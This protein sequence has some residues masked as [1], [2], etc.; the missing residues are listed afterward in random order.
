MT[1]PHRATPE[2]WENMTAFENDSFDV[3]YGSCILELRD[4]IEALEAA[5]ASVQ[6]AVK[7]SLTAPAWSLVERVANAVS[8]GVVDGDYTQV[9]R[10]A[11]REVAAWI[12]LE[13]NGRSVAD[14]LEQ[15]ADQ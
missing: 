14:R 8:N 10:G 11:I 7:D 13:L 1:E 2:K 6:P 12:R 3:G 9:S 4:R 5:Q 15:E